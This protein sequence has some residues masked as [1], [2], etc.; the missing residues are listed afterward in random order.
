MA[1]LAEN[2]KSFRKDA[3]NLWLSLAA[4]VVVV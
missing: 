1:K 4:S 3:S 2:L